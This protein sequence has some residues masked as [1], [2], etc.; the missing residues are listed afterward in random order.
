MRSTSTLLSI[1]LVVCTLVACQRDPDNPAGPLTSSKNRM[2]VNGEGYTN[3]SFN[4]LN[5]D[6][7]AVATTQND[8]G[9]ITLTGITSRITEGFNLTITTASAA[10]GTWQVNALQGTT[11]N[12]VITDGDST[13][14]YTAMTGSVQVSSWPAT[15]R[16]TGTFSGNFARTSDL[17]TTPLQ[18]TAGE[19]D[20]GI[21]VR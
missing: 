8:V 4:T 9:V 17:S 20:A 15:G 1:V 21:I 12:L 3:A 6:T 2:T 19:F 18:I 5:I 14:T 10:A 7:A 13:R 16:V 11:I